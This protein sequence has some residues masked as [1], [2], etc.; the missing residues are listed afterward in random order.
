VNLRRSASDVGITSLG[1]GHLTF[2]FGAP[3][4]VGEVAAAAVP[5]VGSLQLRINIPSESRPLDG[6]RCFKSAAGVFWIW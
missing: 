3:A 5:P 1:T 6:V 4:A 2:V